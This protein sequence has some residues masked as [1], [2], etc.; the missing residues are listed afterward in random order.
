MK[1][2]VAKPD[3]D[4]IKKQFDQSIRGGDPLEYNE[5]DGDLEPYL[6]PLL[7]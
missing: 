7:S 1:E 6:K 4:V 2:T 5:G 3:E